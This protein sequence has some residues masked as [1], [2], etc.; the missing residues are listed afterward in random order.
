LIFESKSE[1]FPVWVFWICDA[2]RFG[3]VVFNWKRGDPEIKEGVLTTDGYGK[4]NGSLGLSPKFEITGD[5]IGMPDDDDRGSVI[6]N[7]DVDEWVRENQN[8][9]L[10]LSEQQK[11]RG[12]L[13]IQLCTTKVQR[14]AGGVRVELNDPASATKICKLIVH[15]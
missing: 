2:L 14:R 6:S 10:R 4:E 15:F 3:I 12:G 1:G 7:L 9:F 11:S 13:T 8:I 5:D